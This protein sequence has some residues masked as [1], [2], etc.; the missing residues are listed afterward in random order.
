PMVHWSHSEPI[1]NSVVKLCYGYDS[2]GVAL[3]HNRSV[4]GLFFIRKALS[5]TESAFLLANFI[6]DD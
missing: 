1:P 4:P 2:L 5:N 3:R 6:S